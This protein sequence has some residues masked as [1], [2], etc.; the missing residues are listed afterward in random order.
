MNPLITD[1]I[2]W[3]MTEIFRFLKG[4]NQFSFPEDM[5]VYVH[6]QRQRLAVFSEDASI[7]TK[8]CYNLLH[9]RC[10]GLRIN[11][12]APLCGAKKNI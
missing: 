4:R 12:K 1:G 10:S 5:E 11:K 7:R 9:G 3:F 6:V 2:N 8:K